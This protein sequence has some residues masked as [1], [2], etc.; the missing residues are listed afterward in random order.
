LLEADIEVEMPDISA[1]WGQL[2]LQ[3]ERAGMDGLPVNQRPVEGAGETVPGD[4]G[5]DEVS[6][7]SEAPAEDTADTVADPADTGGAAG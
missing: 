2:R 7:D 5:R 1:P 6:P 4:S 3:R